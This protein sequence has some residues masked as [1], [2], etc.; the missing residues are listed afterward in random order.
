M[1]R[2]R[3]PADGPAAHRLGRIGKGG[4]LHQRERR[5]LAPALEREMRE[6]ASG[7]AGGAV[8]SRMDDPDGYQGWDLWIEGRKPN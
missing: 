6:Q 5:E 3:H 1:E 2:P 4:L 7:D 8:L